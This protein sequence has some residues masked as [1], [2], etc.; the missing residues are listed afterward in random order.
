V[1]EIAFHAL[2]SDTIEA[3]LNDMASQH[4]ID[5]D[6]IAD[7]EKRLLKEH[8]EYAAFQESVSTD[9]LVKASQYQS[10]EN[11]RL[12]VTSAVA[13]IRELAPN[14]GLYMAIRMLQGVSLATGNKI[15]CIKLLR[16]M[17]GLGL[18]EAKDAIESES[19]DFPAETYE[20]FERWAERQNHTHVSK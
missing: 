11:R 13:R 12:A 18:C 3:L 17:T 10:S 16:E 20:G 2:S 1:V 6:N 14:H 19:A 15:E 7:L 5:Q 9:S 4:A 8:E